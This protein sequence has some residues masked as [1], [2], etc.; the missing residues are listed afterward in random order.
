M[1]VE[2]AYRECVQLGLD[3]GPK[4]CARGS[5]RHLSQL[6]ELRDALKFSGD[7][8]SVLWRSMTV[9]AAPAGQG[10]DRSIRAAA[11][12]SSSQIGPFPLFETVSTPRALLVEHPLCGRVI[13]ALDRDG[14]IEEGE[15]PRTWR[16]D[17]GTIRVAAAPR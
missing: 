9:W 5:P 11:S 16:L 12:F 14:S 8:D 10:P 3:V 1:I 6:D 7:P 17:L 15:E 4:D 13:L 2:W